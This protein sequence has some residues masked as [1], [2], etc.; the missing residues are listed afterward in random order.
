LILCKF[1]LTHMN[2]DKEELKKA[3]S[4]IS[5]SKPAN[6]FLKEVGFQ[7]VKDMIQEEHI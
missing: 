7:I 5:Q 2:N 3:I 4:Q 6:K 1:L